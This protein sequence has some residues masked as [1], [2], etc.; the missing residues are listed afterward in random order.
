MS[1]YYLTKL[2]TNRIIRSGLSFIFRHVRL[3]DAVTAAL[4]FTIIGI[5][6]LT[7]GGAA[8]S[9]MQAD[10]S[11]MSKPQMFRYAL[12][13]QTAAT[14]NPDVILSLSADDVKLMLAAPDLDRRD[15]AGA[16]W[17]YRTA[18]CVLDVFMA[19]DR[20]KHYEFRSRRLGD[21]TAI[22]APSCLKDLYTTRRS[23]IAQAFED[24]FASYESAK[25]AG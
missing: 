15:G 7:L 9:G 5:C 20:I 8:Y 11:S 6:H 19:E 1:F 24:I 18:S 25:D 13:V 22:D 14:Q 17:Q 3:R 21:D 2:R 10:L 16:V 23:L 12:S 4:S